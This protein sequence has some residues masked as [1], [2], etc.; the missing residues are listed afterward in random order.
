MILG[1]LTLPLWV[2][3]VSAQ[4]TAPRYHIAPDGDD[5]AAGTESAPWRTL[6]RVQAAV[7]NVQPGAQF[8]FQRGGSYPGSLEID[9]PFRGTTDAP[10]VFGAYGDGEAPILS[11]LIPLTDWTPAGENRWQ[12]TCPACQPRTD[13]LL[14]DGQAQPFARFPNLDAGDEGYLYFDAA[15]GRSAL[16]DDALA[17]GPDWTGGELVIR[18]IAWVLDR[19]PITGQNGGTLTLGPARDE[20]NYNFKVG[21]GYFLQN[22]PAALDQDGEWVWDAAAQTITLY[23]SS[24]PAQHRLQ[25]T[26]VDKVVSLANLAHVELR[27]LTI[28]GGRDYGLDILNCERLRVL[29]VTVRF[30]AADAIQATNCTD[31]ELA[32]SHIHDHLTHGFRSWNCAACLVHHNHIERIGLLAGMGRGGDGQYNG[33]SLNGDQSSMEFNRIEYIGYNPLTIAGSVSARYNLIQHFAL[34]KVDSGGI[35][36]WRT[37]GGQIIGNT[38][39]Y[40]LGSDAAIPWDSPAVNGIYIDD[41]SENIEV[42]DNVVGYMGG[43]GIVLHNTRN[44][45]VVNNTV[46]AAGESGIILTDD[47][48]GTLESTDSLI[49][50]NRIFS[51]GLDA[52]PLR[53][54]T[55][56]LGEAWLGRLGTLRANRYCNPLRANPI[57]VAFQPGWLTR[58]LW[59]ARWQTDYGY[60][61]NSRDCGLRYPPV[62]ETGDP[63]PNRISNSTLNSTADGWS[64]WPGS[65]L[66]LGWDT[67]WGGSLRVGHIGSDPGVL[68]YHGIGAVEAGQAFR[69]RFRAQAE[70]DGVSL[71][72]YLQQAGPDYGWWSEPVR[73][74]ID[75]ADAVHTVYVTAR[76]ADPNLRLTFDLQRGAGGQPQRLWLD[77]IEVVP[78]AV[79]P[80]PLESVARL[81]TNATDAAIEVTLDDQVYLDLDGTRY[82]P[83]STLT[84]APYTGIILVR[85]PSTPARIGL[86]LEPATAQPGEPVTLHL[87]ID[88]ANAVYGLEAR[89]AVD[90]AVLTGVAHADGLVFENGNSFFVDSG[91]GADGVWNIAASRLNPAPPFAGAGTLFSLGYTAAAP[92][93]TPITCTVLAVDRDGNALPVTVGEAQFTVGG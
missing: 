32:N 74:R 87:N 13:L 59:L 52:F 12:T 39:L 38:V 19:Y 63:G 73:L 6:A 33:A 36:T 86:V 23:L 49:E 69:V 29:N 90:P 93:T 56:L 83:G 78:V 71:A 7:D 61:Q 80:V 81:E 42:R 57:S 48:L 88:G 28:E 58:D 31:F 16:T 68:S 40:G 1:L 35:G 53:A 47:H 51:F 54:Q 60:D 4:V 17:G 10:V 21:Y 92:G 22:H 25:T 2:L 44:I 43:N 34:V 67:R 3:P 77:D 46:F 20:T 11:G 37:S 65:S 70:T 18:S 26:A 50:N 82:A 15:T 55:S 72:V 66:E 91:P 8:L 64:G 5:S 9:Y 89:C 24:H 45:Q 85:E 27:D 62:T 41:N 30:G 76:E 75:R 84:L 79:E 14:L